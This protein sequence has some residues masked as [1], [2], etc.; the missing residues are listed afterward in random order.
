MNIQSMLKT[1]TNIVIRGELYDVVDCDTD[2]FQAT[3]EKNELETIAY[4]DI[5]L[6]ED[7]VVIYHVNILYP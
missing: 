5:D 6:E 1:A 2:F 7:E 3:N 4:D